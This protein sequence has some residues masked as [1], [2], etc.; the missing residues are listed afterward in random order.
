MAK[1]QIEVINGLIELLNA[2]MIDEKFS[3]RFAMQCRTFKRVCNNVLNGVNPE[4]D[5]QT[6]IQDAIINAE[7]NAENNG[8]N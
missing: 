7:N 1:E 5:G 4:K 2:V 8:E 6:N 3:S